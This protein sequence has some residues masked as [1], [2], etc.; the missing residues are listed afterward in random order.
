MTSTSNPTVQL[1]VEIKDPEQQLWLALLLQI[2][3]DPRK[4]I[5][6]KDFLC[7]QRTLTPAGYQYRLGRIASYPVQKN[8]LP[9]T[10]SGIY[11]DNEVSCLI[12]IYAAIHQYHNPEPF[13]RRLLETLNKL[14]DRLTRGDG[15]MNID[16]GWYGSQPRPADVNDSFF[17]VHRSSRKGCLMALGLHE[18]AV[19]YA[20][21]HA[22]VGSTVNYAEIVRALLRQ[23]WVTKTEMHFFNHAFVVNKKR[24]DKWMKQNIN[25]FLLPVSVALKH[26]AKIQEEDYRKF[27]EESMDDFDLME[28]IDSGSFNNLFITRLDNAEGLERDKAARADA[29]ELLGLSSD[30][31]SSEEDNPQK[32]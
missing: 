21:K 31:V 9:T 2:K 19:H 4:Y 24:I 17:H 18:V 1:T 5:T 10:T 26:E 27:C 25:R 14:K 7:I 30:T 11:F 32:S 29:R 15:P 13:Q 3:E 22:P 6:Y 12:H 23:T 28:N 20:C 16:Q 8:V